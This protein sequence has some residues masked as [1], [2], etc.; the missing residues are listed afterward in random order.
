MICRYRN[1]RQEFVPRKMNQKYCNLSCKSKEKYCRELDQNETGP[2]KIGSEIPC[3][4][5]CGVVIIKK[6]GNTKYCESCKLKRKRE[7][8]KVW[9]GKGNGVEVATQP[10]HHVTQ[11]TCPWATG[12]LKYC[13]R[14][15]A[16]STS[17][18]PMG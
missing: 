1:C 14:I 11:T 7:Y 12:Q 18:A 8:Q 4:G 5:E 16:N 9:R 15:A 17:Y 13:D 6:S 10:L 2:E 3:A